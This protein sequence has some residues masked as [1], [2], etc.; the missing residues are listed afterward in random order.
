MNRKNILLAMMFLVGTPAIAQKISPNTAIKLGEV[1]AAKRLKAATPQ[2]FSAFVTISDPAAVAEMQALG[3][4]V[5]S[6]MGDNLVVATIPYSAVQAVA[7]LDGVVN[8]QAGTE[9]RMLLDTAR[10]DA[11][12]DNCQSTTSSLG[13]FTGKGVVVGIVD[14]GFEYGHAAFLNADRS[15][16]RI[17]RVWDQNST[18]GNSPV[19]FGY[20]TEYKSYEEIKAAAYDRTNSFHG[21]HVANIAAGGDRDC[22]YY[23]VAP[24]ADIVL[25]S[26]NEETDKIA[27]GIKYCFDY[28]ESVGKPCVVN[29]SLGSHLGPHD[30]TSSTDQAFASLVGPGRIIVGAAGNEGSDNLHAMKTFVDGDTEMKTIIGF[31][32]SSSYSS[33]AYVD[34]WGDKNSP[35]SVKVIAIDA[36]KGKTMAA[37]PA[38]STDGEENVSYVFP[39]GSGVVADLTLARQ[40]NPLNGRTEVLL[41]LRASSIGDNRKVAIVVSGEAGSTVHMWNNASGGYF[42]SGDRRGWTDGDTE[43]TVGELGGVSKD[44]ITVGSYNTKLSYTALDGNEYGFNSKVTGGVGERS[45]FSSC[46]PTVDGRTKPDVT[47]PGC[48]LVSATSRYYYSFSATTAAG[49]SNDCYYDANAGTSM[50]SPFVAGTVALWLQANPNLTTEDVRAILEKT[51]RHDFYTGLKA[52]CDPNQWGAGKIDAFSGLRQA[53]NTTGVSDAT[54]GDDM[55]SIV[56]DRSAHTAQFFFG[57]ADGSAKMA[58][59]NTMGQQVY[60]KQLSASGETVDLSHLGS[61][62]FVFKLQQGDSVKA[63]KAAM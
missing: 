9:A 58:V 22:A 39:D 16:T 15:D 2:T 13:S 34:I 4:N 53:L 63:V 32:S 46:G 28:A 48:A 40:N 8:I 27:E 56:T 23:G 20:G 54:V 30:G 61:G 44:V 36:L 7:A 51:S 41:K 55:F 24:D 59:Y 18:A 50:A 60:A 42:M 14:G 26:F 57:S 35:I 43:Y 52:N 37:S 45:L 21:S 29:I 12:V 1:S 38:V 33:Q 5:T 47:A 25:V 31:N 11:K 17:K 3:V 62:V 19:A 49:K 10:K 6:T